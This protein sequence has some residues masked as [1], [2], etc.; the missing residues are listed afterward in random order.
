MGTRGAFVIPIHDLDSAGREHAFTVPAVWLRGA[1]EGCEA[2]PAG[3]DAKLSVFVAK[4]GRDVLVHGGVSVELVVPCA[5][6][7]EPVRFCPRI[8]LSL[9]LRP[10]LQ[11]PRGPI[12]APG[13]GKRPAEDEF[14]AEDADVDTFDGDEVVLDPF[15]REAILLESPIFPLCSEAC[16]GIRRPEEAGPPASPEGPRIKDPRFL[17]LLEL[18]KKRP[19]KE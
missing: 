19:I 7:L 16:E 18:A 11:Q 15:V 4:T 6:C 2:Q 3:T 13:A 14:S 17:P 12:S 1:L 9:S 5:R 10:V 8:A